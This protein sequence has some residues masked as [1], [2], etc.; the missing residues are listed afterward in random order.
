LSGEGGEGWG[1]GGHQGERGGIQGVSTRAVGW[2]GLGKG[3]GAEGALGEKWVG[4]M[5]RE[6]LAGL[7]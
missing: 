2:R 6:G 4:S 3:R 1:T 7:G 5:V